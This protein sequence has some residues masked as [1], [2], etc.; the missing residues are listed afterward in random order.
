MD[1]KTDEVAQPLVVVMGVSGCGKSTVGTALAEALRVPYA[2]ADDFHPAA[3]VA[4]MAAGT[5]LD[6]EDRWPWLDRVA[7]WLG[8]HRDSGG[9]VSCSAL[10]RA[11]RDLL[12][13]DASEAVFVHLH[14]DRDV[15]TERLAR[16]PGHFMPATL[17]DSQLDTLEPLE[18]D[19]RGFVLDV[20]L[21]VDVLVDQAV[22]RLA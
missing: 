20:A 10:K 12:T 2:D 14:A 16:R 6:D 5:P 7:A 17:I 9:V 3:N 4:K 22:D 21:P 18:A 13:A 11:Y 15:L 1:G 19:E 8:D